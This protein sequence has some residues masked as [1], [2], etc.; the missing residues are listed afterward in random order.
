MMEDIIKYNNE[1]AGLDFKAIQYTK[2]KYPSLL[3][4]II[5]M[6]NADYKDNRFIIVGIKHLPSGEKKPIS[7]EKKDFIDSSTYQQLINENIESDI[8]LSYESYL[9]NDNSTLGIFCLSDCN[10]QPYMLKKDYG[11]L[12]KGDCFI[13]KGSHQIKATRADFERMYEE[14]DPFID[15]IK[16]FFKDTKVKTIKVSSIDRKNIILKSDRQI[17]KIE[18]II[19]IKKLK[20]NIIEKK[21]PMKISL[22]GLHTPLENR[23][24]EE[25]NKMLKTAKDTYREDDLYEYQEEYTYKLNFDIF[26]SSI[27]YIEDASIIITIAKSDNYFILDIPIEKP[28]NT[29]DALSNS[30]HR[31]TYINYPNVDNVNNNFIIS[32]NIGDIKH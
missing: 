25:L 13:R 14:R 17:K 12:K 26:N 30:M 28:S 20:N 4:D 24:I 23:N 31:L 11:N 21:L 9:Y 22:N 8:N 7:I 32:T 27:K 5:A 15:K 10:K 6:A 16:I 2:D 19:K 3:K 29:F 18:D 1:N